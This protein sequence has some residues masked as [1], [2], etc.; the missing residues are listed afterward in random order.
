MFYLIIS[1]F[2]I[3]AVQGLCIVLLWRKN[4][5]LS[6]HLTEKVNVALSTAIRYNEE[7]KAATDSALSEY[8]NRTD[9]ID[10]VIRG[11]ERQIADLERGVCPDYEKAKEAASWLDKFNDSVTGYL[12]Y[13]MKT[14]IHSRGGGI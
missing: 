2:C 14:A 8:R 10:N 1:L 6:C 11:Q 12:S 7:L 13:D 3:V 9:A 4:Y 5:E